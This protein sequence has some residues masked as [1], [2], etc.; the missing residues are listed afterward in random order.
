MGLDIDIATNNDDELIIS[1]YFDEENGYHNKHSLSRTFC[2]LMCQRNASSYE[3]ELD[4]IGKITGVDISPLYEMENHPEE[5]CSEFFPEN[6]GSGAEKDRAKLNGNID[7][8]LKTINDL[9][10]KFGSIAN[11]PALLQPTDFTMRNTEYFAEFN[12]DKGTGYIGNNFGQ[13]L[14]N[15][16]RFLEFAKER[17]TTTVWFRYG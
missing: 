1:G 15:F 2:N 12:L 17:G 11:L 13:D 8:V 10:D 14:R 3:P 6:T 16:K 5:E 7:T 9:I 4:Q